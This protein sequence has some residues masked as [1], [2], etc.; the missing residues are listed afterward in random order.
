MPRPPP[1]PVMPKYIYWIYL[2]TN[3]KYSLKPL[4]FSL[5]L[6]IIIIFFVC[7]N[8][9]LQIITYVQCGGQTLHN[10]QK[11]KRIYDLILKSIFRSQVKYRQI[12]YFRTYNN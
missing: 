5:V 1:L 7:N 11:S 9:G 3:I 12:L 8:I 4:H 10:I 2:H 6:T